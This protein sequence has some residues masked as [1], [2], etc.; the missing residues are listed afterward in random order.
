MSSSLSWV[1]L[2][3]NFYKLPEIHENKDVY[4]KHQE[5]NL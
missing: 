1:K 4:E 3:V 2:P 5:D